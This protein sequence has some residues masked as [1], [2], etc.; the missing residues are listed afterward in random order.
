M[1]LWLALSVF[2]L[3]GIAGLSYELTWLRYLIHLFGATTPAV[4]ATVAIFFTGLAILNPND[5]QA[6]AIIQVF[7]KD[8]EVIASKIEILPPRGRRTRLLTEYF[9]QLTAED[10]DSGYIEVTSIRGL[11]GFALFGAIDLSV[12]SAVPPQIV[13]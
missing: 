8:G 10:L 12:L 4:S 5:V 2:F 13:P 6:N 9:P 1:G 11:A 7:N 3:S